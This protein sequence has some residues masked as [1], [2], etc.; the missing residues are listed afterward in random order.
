MAF[1]SKFGNVLRQSASKQINSDLSP[2]KL[3]THQAVR[4]MSSMGSSKVFIGGVS[5]QT[6]DAGLREAFGRYGDVVDARIITDRE[7]GR[8]R[9]F[10]FVTYTTPEEASSAIQGL[11]GKDLHGRIIRVNYATDRPRGN[12]SY[13]GG[14]GGYSGGYGG[15]R[16]GGGSYSGGGGGGGGHNSF[17]ND[18]YSSAGNYGSL[19]SLE[20]ASGGGFGNNTDFGRPSGVGT[21]GADNFGVGGGGD[22]SFPD[23]DDQFGYQNRA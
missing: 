12:F 16:G 7:T 13:G 4:C 15:G 18:S 11:D 20:I 5:Y 21:G 9:G 23:G 19:N 10:G 6:D 8:S 1:L 22:N 3:W 2:F 14:D 17:G